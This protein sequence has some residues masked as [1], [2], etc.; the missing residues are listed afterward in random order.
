MTD[1]TQAS[2]GLG[3]HIYDYRGH[4]V[5]E[6]GGAIDGFRAKVLL[7]PKQKVGVVVLGNSDQFEAVLA[8]SYQVL[9]HLL[10][11]EK[12]D[13]N[14]YYTDL[15]KRAAAAAQA[16]REQFEAG[17]KPDAKPSRE[18]DAYVGTFEDAA[19][20]TLTVTKKDGELRLSWSTFEG[21]LDHYHD[22]AF[23]L[24]TSGRL[25]DTLATFVLGS[26]KAVTGVKFVGRTFKRVKSK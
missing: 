3:W 14:G 7:A 11:L 17:R 21:K 23:T 13:W 2:Y 18:P 9:D 8:T 22:D 4:L 24:T 6:H 19:Y 25:E 1:M 16:R 15:M 10:G 5:W 20:G 26:D 12:R